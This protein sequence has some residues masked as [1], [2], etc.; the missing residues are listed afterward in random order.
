MNISCEAMPLTVIEN[1]T[2][3]VLPP[4]APPRRP[5]GHRQAY[6]SPVAPFAAGVAVWNGRERIKA[7]GARSVSRAWISD[8]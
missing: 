8:G 4:G 1:R 5:V 2:A 7:P 3:H 6:A